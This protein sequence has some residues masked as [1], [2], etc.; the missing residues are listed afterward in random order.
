MVT[1]PE[2]MDECFYFTNRTLENDG[3]IIAWVYKP[4]CPKCGKVKMGKPVD[5]KTGKVKSRAK[6]YT[7]KECGYEVD[8]EEM[9]PNL[10]VEIEYKCPHCGDEGEA[11][12]EYQLKTW[13]G[14][15]AYVFTCNKCGEKIG[16]T[17]KMKKPKAPKPK[18]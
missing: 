1:M 8:K 12:T 7:C 2:S 13:K 5:P 14:V 17:K 9:D 3:T 11:T 18:K 10:K 6:I 15:K 4:M 16:V